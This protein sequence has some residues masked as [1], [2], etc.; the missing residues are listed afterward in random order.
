M[1]DKTYKVIELV[2]VSQD[3]VQAA[4]RNGIK[5]AAQS[6]KGLAWFEVEEIRGNI[7]DGDVSEFQVSM[8]VGFRILDPKE[9]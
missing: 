8:K 4:I 3:S 9:I 2:G 7:T 5:R 6:L 1:P